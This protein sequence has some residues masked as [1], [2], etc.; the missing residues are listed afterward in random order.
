M[1]LAITLKHW[2]SGRLMSSDRTIVDAVRV[3]HNILSQS[4][5]PA[6]HAGTVFRLSELV[7]SSS[8]RSALERGS[9]TLPAFALRQIAHVLSNHSQ[10]HAETIARIRDILDD[11]HL[12]ELFRQNSRIVFGPRPSRRP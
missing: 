9:D 8:V 1:D 4:L 12:N 3:A 5:G 10:T 7:E 6:T 11:P 2:S